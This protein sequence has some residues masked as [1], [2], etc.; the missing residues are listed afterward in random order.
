MTFGEAFAGRRVLVTG[1]TGFKGAWLSSWLLELGA[2]VT[3]YS[4]Q[5]PTQPSLF[6]ALDLETRL[7]QV[8]ADVRDRDRLASA[9]A[10]ARPEVIFHLAAQSLVGVGYSNPADTFAINT[11]GTVNLLEAARTCESVRAVVVVTS[12]KSYRNLDLGRPFLEDDAM[13]GHDPYSASK[14]AAELVTGAY[15]DSFFSGPDIA[16]LASVR[17]GNVIG[18][19]DWAAERIIPDCVRALTAGQPIVVRNPDAVRPWQH[20]LEPLSGYLELA[21]RLLRDGKAYAEP[22]NFGPSAE[23][24]SRAVQW[25]VERFLEAWGT[26]SWTAAVASINAPREARLLG[27]DSAK[28]RDRL[29]WAPVWDASAAVARTATWYRDFGTG[30]S[31]TATRE[32]VSGQLREYVGAARAAGRAWASEAVPAG[33]GAVSS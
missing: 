32:L 9:V 30:M 33:R 13:G 31:V 16:A 11:L 17:A 29:G 10:A 15:R 12:D 5:P 3:G 28:A 22:W 19:G 24:G 7:H 4:L 1:D 6:R 25:V 14:G 18:G 20:V 2:D 27:L 26:G 21:A 23:D 8:V